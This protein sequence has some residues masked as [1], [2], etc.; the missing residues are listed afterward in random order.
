MAKSYKVSV[1][2]GTKVVADMAQQVKNATVEASL[3]LKPI[4]G[5]ATEGT[6]VL[7]PIPNPLPVN[8]NRKRSKAIGWYKN[9]TGP[10]WE[11]PKGFDNTNWWSYETGLWSL[12]SSVPMLNSP[13]DGVV[14]PANTKAT[15]G[16]TVY[17]SIDDFADIPASP[18][19]FILRAGQLEPTGPNGSVTWLCADINLS[20]LSTGDKLTFGLVMQGANFV[21]AQPRGRFYN[22][23]SLVS[24]FLSNE[25]IHSELIP[26][27][28]NRL[29]VQIAYDSYTGEN[30][31]A[32]LANS[33]YLKKFGIAK[34]DFAKTTVRGMA[35]LETK[36]NTLSTSVQA[37]SNSIT[38]LNSGQT[39]Y[40]S[41]YNV[42]LKNSQFTK[43]DILSVANNTY[44]TH[45]SRFNF[46][47]TGLHEL[48][49]KYNNT[50]GNGAF[51]RIF[52]ES[53]I[54]R[55]FVTFTVASGKITGATLFEVALDNTVTSLGTFTAVNQV[56]LSTDHT[57]K[58]YMQKG[59]LVVYIDGV[60]VL[61]EDLSATT[62]ISDDYRIG[63]SWRDYANRYNVLTPKARRFEKYVHFSIDDVIYTLLEL[64]TSMNSIFDH[65]TFKALQDINRATGAKFSLFLFYAL[66]SNTL[67]NVV[68]KFKDEFKA[69]SSW[70]KL[71]FHG[72]DD[73]IVYANQV[74]DQRLSND[75]KQVYDQIK[76]FASAQ[77]I[78]MFP[79]MSMFSAKRS[80]TNV[81]FDA[82]LLKG[83]LS[84][85]DNRVSNSGLTDAEK[86]CA[87]NS[88][89][90]LDSNGMVYLRSEVRLDYVTSAN[91]V[92]QVYDLLNNK[93]NDKFFEFFLHEP[94][95]VAQKQVMIDMANA[96]K[97]GSNIKFG[98]PQDNF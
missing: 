83:I 22:G 52:I 60:L 94:N 97:Q 65:A 9:A 88:D 64:N 36:T 77:N 82:G 61:S 34:G 42:R 18:L 45:L 81:A 46:E 98:F 19:S 87:T 4:T 32:D 95:I 11:A 7:L 66:G 3:E 72:Y 21:S 51:A 86:K 14:M 2:A 41:K 16:D 27:T 8:S 50:T 59:F 71:G 29:I 96:I 15:S 91:G 26:A 12:G 13:A 5:G 69:N 37:N 57:V 24:S 75:I 89:F 17:K 38:D 54:N 74:D 93:N 33:P 92:K 53:S 90:L 39:Y 44:P 80:A 20:G 58:A 76:R 43:N 73:T 63:T 68:D 84:A 49:F 35:A 6:A 70:L 56:T 67:S 62:N 47:G 28:A 30:V 40:N 31:G 79:R 10:A 85:D 23:S 55:Y 78:D 25:S 48:E 1:F